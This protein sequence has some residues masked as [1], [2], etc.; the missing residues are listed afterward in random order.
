V[1]F[2]AAGARLVVAAGDACGCA[3]RFEA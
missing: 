1:P 2:Q 3:V